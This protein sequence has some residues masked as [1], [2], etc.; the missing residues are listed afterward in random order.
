MIGLIVT[1]EP[2]HLMN[3]P[4][5]RQLLELETE[6]TTPACICSATELEKLV[7]ITS[8]TTAQVMVAYI[9]DAEKR[10]GPL[11]QALSNPAFSFG[12]ND[13]IDEGWAAM[14]YIANRAFNAER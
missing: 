10:Y 4:E 8:H 5:H 13:V 14:P 1:M 3:S 7:T 9:D 6:P 11:K 2:F 12:R